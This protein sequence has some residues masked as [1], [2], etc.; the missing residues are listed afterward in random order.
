MGPHSRKLGWESKQND[1]PKIKV[2][3]FVDWG[4]KKFGK[5][6]FQPKLHEHNKARFINNSV[7][8]GLKYKKQQFENFNYYYFFTTSLSP[9]LLT[10]SRNFR[11]V[12]N[13]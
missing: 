13:K 3:L 6:E 11:R 7:V 1:W 5:L 2:K 10:F 8:F 4:L 12:S 9:T